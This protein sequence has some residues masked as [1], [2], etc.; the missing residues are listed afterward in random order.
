MPARPPTAE[1]VEE[2]KAILKRFRR[3]LEEKRRKFRDYLTVLEKQH[4][5]ISIDNVDAMLAHAELEQGIVAEIYTVQKVIDPLEE[6]YRAAYPSSADVEIP[7]LQ[8]DLAKLQK[9]V[10]AQNDRNR[11][12]LKVRMQELRQKVQGLQSG[13]RKASVY[14]AE[15]HTAKVIDI[16]Q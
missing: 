9:D 3:L 15:A 4:E 12:L 8:A 7:K 10:L 6:M 13:P 14:A 1:E 2:R 16:S 11:E 5:M